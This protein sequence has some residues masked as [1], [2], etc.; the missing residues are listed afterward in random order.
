LNGDDG[1]RL[2]I[3]KVLLIDRWNTCCD[4]MQVTI[5]LVE[6]S[7][8][9]IVL[10]YKELQFDAS[11]SLE[12]YSPSVHREIIPSTNLYY[13]QRVNNVVYEVE[14]IKGPTIPN[15]STVET[16]PLVLVAGK[17]SKSTYQSRNWY[18]TIIENDDDSYGTTF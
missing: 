8:Y 3:D 6:G 1:F 11:L 2:Y 18:G 14:V 16:N 10:E 7:F 9:D 5:P 4:E 13:S 15:M 12:W 17:L